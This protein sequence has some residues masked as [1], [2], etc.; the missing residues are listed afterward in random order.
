MK[1]MATGKKASA[2]KSLCSG[3]WTY[4]CAHTKRE[5]VVREKRGRGKREGERD[6][7][8]WVA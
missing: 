7:R 5:R 1:K 6:N 2:R 3:S 8:S 4:T